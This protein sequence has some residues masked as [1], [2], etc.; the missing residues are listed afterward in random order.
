MQQPAERVAEQVCPYKVCDRGHPLFEC[1]SVSAAMATARQVSRAWGVPI[2]VR[3]YCL[4]IR[5]WVSAE[6]SREKSR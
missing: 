3:T 2:E 1:A 6:F 5:L 4:R